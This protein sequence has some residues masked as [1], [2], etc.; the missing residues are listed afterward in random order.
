M[1]KFKK[2]LIVFIF[3]FILLLIGVYLLIYNETHTFFHPLYHRW[4]I[5][6]ERPYEDEGYFFLFFGIILMI[7][8]AIYSHRHIKD[9]H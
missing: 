3:G 1:S 9:L 4:I 7:I 5:L 8:G 2:G 6:T